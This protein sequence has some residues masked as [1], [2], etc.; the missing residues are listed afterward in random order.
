MA[1]L[2]KK[3]GGGVL[4][5]KPGVGADGF[6]VVLE[7][8]EHLAAA[9]DHGAYEVALAVQGVGGDE[10]VVEGFFVFNQ[11]PSGLYFAAVAFAFF[12]RGAGNGEGNAGLVVGEADDAGD[13]ADILAVEREG[14]AVRLANRSTCTRLRWPLKTAMARVE[15]MVPMW[16]LLLP[17]RAASSDC[18]EKGD[19]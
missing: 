11:F 16:Y 4:E 13:V 8:D 17:A 6:L 19:A 2:F 5:F 9:L 14:L 10:G 12:L 15:S 18:P 3:K 1:F 7:L